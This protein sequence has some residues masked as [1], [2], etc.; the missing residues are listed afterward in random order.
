MSAAAQGK[1]AWRNLK[2]ARD[3]ALLYA[4]TDD[5][6]GARV[7][8]ARDGSL[9]GEVTRARRQPINQGA[10]APGVTPWSATSRSCTLDRAWR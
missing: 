8:R 6:H 9:D 5:G 7:I 3:V 2:A 4:P 1:G 10:G